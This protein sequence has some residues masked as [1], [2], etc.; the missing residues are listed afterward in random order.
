MKKLVHFFPL[1]SSNLVDRN[2]IPKK[3]LRDKRAK[4]GKLL[5]AFII[6][7]NFTIDKKKKR[8]QNQRICAC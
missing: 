2:K 3:R 6:D 5:Q 8:E 1:N 4:K 7:V